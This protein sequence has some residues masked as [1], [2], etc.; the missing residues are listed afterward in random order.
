MSAVRMGQS[1]S[2]PRVLVVDD[3]RV[4]RFT[5]SKILDGEFQVIVANDGEQGW[6]TAAQQ[7]PDLVISD[8]NMPNLDGYGLICK[9]R[10]ADTA[11]LRDVPVIVITSA[12]DDIVRERAYACG[13]NAF[14]LKPFDA[15][16]LVDSVRLHL[17]NHEASAG[18][19]EARYGNHIEDI[20]VSDVMEMPE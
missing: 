17:T 12:E 11:K 7:R 6:D 2:K 16:E 9:L 14:I 5:V 19:L 4:V 20:V 18:D 8:I 15:G 13:A 1:A 3:S 10:G